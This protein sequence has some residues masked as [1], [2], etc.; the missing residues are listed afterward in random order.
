M[1]TAMFESL[2]QEGAVN[3]NELS[4]ALKSLL[5]GGAD[6]QAFAEQIKALLAPILTTLL[7]LAIPVVIYLL[8]AYILR[9]IALYKIAHRRHIAAPGLAW[10]PF[11]WKYTLGAIA[12]R[13]DKRLGYKRRWRIVILVLMVISLVL[14]IAARVFTKTV[15]GKPALLIAYC[16]VMGCASLAL[17]TC[18]TICDYKLFESCKPKAAIFNMLFCVLLPIVKPFVLIAICGKDS[19]KD[20]VIEEQA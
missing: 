7:L 20:R 3:F 8:V 12:D 14:G 2:G 5:Q 19:K 13:H 17:Q 1:D 4:E 11:V 10:V 9:S 6:A 18:R 16:V 15:F